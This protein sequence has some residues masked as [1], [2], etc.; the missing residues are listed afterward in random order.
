MNN[1]YDFF[2]GE[3]ITPDCRYK[4][5]HMRDGLCYNC[6]RVAVPEQ[7]LCERHRRENNARIQACRKLHAKQ[8]E[9]AIA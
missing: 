8:K 2:F 1:V 9:K 5:R 6:A 4:L 3:S 7:R